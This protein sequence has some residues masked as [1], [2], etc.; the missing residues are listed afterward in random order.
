MKTLTG[1]CFFNQT[2]YKPP[3]RKYVNLDTESQRAAVRAD[4]EEQK[5]LELEEEL[6]IV[7]SNLQQLEVS[8]E[9][10]LGKCVNLMSIKD[11][12]NNIGR[13]RFK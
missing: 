11:V 4:E 5:I 7:G 13:F 1:S 2:R 8:E 10:A 3:S 9:K 12:Y 6:R